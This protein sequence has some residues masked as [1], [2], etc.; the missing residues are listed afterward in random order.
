[1]SPR[2]RLEPAIVS[3]AVLAWP[4]ELGYDG[5][6]LCARCLGKLRGPDGL[7]L[8]GPGSI[9]DVGIFVRAVGDHMHA[10]PD[11]RY[12]VEYWTHDRPL[13]PG[14]PPIPSAAQQSAARDQQR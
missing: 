7:R 4:V 6:A 11:R 3:A 14:T 1:M 5:E 10:C 2:R 12:E 9:T 13:L 8:G